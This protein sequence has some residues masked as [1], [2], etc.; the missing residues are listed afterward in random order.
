MN[1]NTPET[2]LKELTLH[3]AQRCATHQ[4]FGKIKLNKI[5]FFADVNAY[6]HRGRPITG[7]NYVKREFGPVPEHMSERIKEL[8]DARDAALEE[9][10]MPDMTQQ[11]RV[12]ALRK[13]DLSMFTAEDIS[14]VSEV[15]DWFRPVSAND[16]S[17][18]SHKSVGWDVARMGEIIPLATAI[19]PDV[20]R[21]LTPK[22]M[23][24]GA[25][26]AQQAARLHVG[27]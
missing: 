11:K 18:I 6:L 13:P 4:L 21:P 14:I 22:E 15:I 9:R 26:L 16:V 7:V 8:Q 10:D 1:T 12:V 2:K 25:R 5:L 19:I 23:Q 3:I 27:A 17:E 24:T 20:Q